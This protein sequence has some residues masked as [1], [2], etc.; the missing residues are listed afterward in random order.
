MSFEYIEINDKDLIP[1]C[2]SV[3]KQIFQLSEIDT[4]PSI[5]FNMLIRKEHPLGIVIGC[6]KIENGTK[7]LI[8]LTVTI[9]SLTEN[10]LYCVLVGVLPEFQNG[11]HGYM[12]ALKLRETALK[13]GLL[14]VYGIYD[15]LEANL[16]KLYAHIGG[17]TTK[18]IQEPYR[19]SNIESGID[20]VLYEWQ[21]DSKRVKDKLQD[22][23]SANFQKIISKKASFNS[24]DSFATELLLE[25]PNNFIELKNINPN[26][27]DRWRIH[28]REILKKY[29]NQEGYFISECVSGNV[30]GQKKTYYLLSRKQKNELFNIPSTPN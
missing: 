20:K 11:R 27:A 9:S 12:F 8:G 1:D 28:T 2:V 23:K 30:N 25:I 5:F 6:F 15:P 29:L 4:L 19:L 18:Y 16:G 17:I 13:K 7:M 24:T 22:R 10:S 26:E 21:L 3:H 14:K